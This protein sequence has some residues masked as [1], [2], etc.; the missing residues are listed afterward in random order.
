M[1][2][3]NRRPQLARRSNATK[4][5]RHNAHAVVAA[6]GV[7]Q[8]QPQS[9]T[10]LTHVIR[11]FFLA[12]G[13]SQFISDFFSFSID[14]GAGRYDVRFQAKAERKEYVA[15]HPVPVGPTDTVFE[16]A[17][18]RLEVTPAEANKAETDRLL[19]QLAAEEGGDEPEEGG[20]AD[21]GD[22]SDE[23]ANGGGEV[24]ESSD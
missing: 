7:M 12:A 17:T 19:A 4:L 10:P 22:D 5:V 21:E 8:F 16:E 3:I 15:E 24:D 14:D 23:D 1:H 6:A 18:Q 9:S 11:I 13:P 20:D 2:T